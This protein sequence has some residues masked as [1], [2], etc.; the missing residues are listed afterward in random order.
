MAK[1]IF[2]PLENLNNKLTEIRNHKFLTGFIFLII[3]LIV[4]GFLIF[5]FRKTEKIEAGSG[6]NV[7]RENGVIGKMGSALPR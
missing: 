5:N 1:K 3:F 6:D 7:Y 4:F 2:T